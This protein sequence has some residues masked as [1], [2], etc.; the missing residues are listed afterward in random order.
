MLSTRGGAPRRAPGD[1]DGHS[2]RSS[3]PSAARRPQHFHT[4]CTDCTSVQSRSRSR[5]TSQPVHPPQGRPEANPTAARSCDG[6][7]VSTHWLPPR[8]PTPSFFATAHS[9]L[10]FL[11]PR[12]FSSTLQTNEMAVYRRPPTAFFFSPPQRGRGSSDW[13]DVLGSSRPFTNHGERYTPSRVVQ[14]MRRRARRLAVQFLPRLGSFAILNASGFSLRSGRSDW[15]L[16]LLSTLFSSQPRSKAIPP[17]VASAAFGIP[18]CWAA[19]SGG[20]FSLVIQAA[21]LFPAG[22]TSKRRL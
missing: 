22:A 6:T 11:T 19:V 9:S 17:S 15:P 18:R 4:G 7:A 12:R 2:P 1:E 14:P 8:P 20:V 3:A 16:L 5:P 10:P 13:P 21:R